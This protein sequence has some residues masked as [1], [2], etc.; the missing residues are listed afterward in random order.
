MSESDLAYVIEKHAVEFLGIEKEAVVVP[1]KPVQR[2]RKPMNEKMKINS[3]GAFTADTGEGG[4]GYV[5][6]DGDGMVLYAG[7]GNLMRLT[8]AT[9]AE[10]RACLEGAK[11]AAALGMGN[12]I[13]ET[14]SLVLAQAMENNGYRLSS[15]GGDILELKN[16]IRENF[17][18]CA[19]AYVPRSCNKVAHSLAT[20]GCMCSPE[21]DL[22]WNGSP[23]CIVDLVASDIAEPIS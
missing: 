7:A 23:S 3:D 20:L 6:R 16:F 1:N 10:V 18:S 12:V 17:N 22:A 11:A 8:E 4:W 21:V 9:Q 5:I 19:V 14:D 15:F 2:W 13:L